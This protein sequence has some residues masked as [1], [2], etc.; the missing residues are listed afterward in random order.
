MKHIVSIALVAVS[1]VV[2]GFGLL[3][4][5]AA[6]QATSQAQLPQWQDLFNG[7]DLTGWVNINTARRH[8]E[9]RATAC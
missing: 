2:A 7:K 1:A 4:V 9:V 3:P 6:G 8:L 5:A